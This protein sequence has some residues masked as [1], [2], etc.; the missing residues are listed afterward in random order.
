[1]IN[2]I[3]RCLVMFMLIFSVNIAQSYCD[4]YLKMS[5]SHL[6]VLVLGSV[7]V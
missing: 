6:A 7:S 3:L 1:M 4:D 5:K 2:Y